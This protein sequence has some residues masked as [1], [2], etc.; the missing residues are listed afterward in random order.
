MRVTSRVA[1]GLIY[2]STGIVVGVAL[3]ATLTAHLSLPAAVAITFGAAAPV[4]IAMSLYRRK[5]LLEEQKH[6]G[7]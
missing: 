1:F 6:D 2:T 7:S 3:T 4:A 5:I